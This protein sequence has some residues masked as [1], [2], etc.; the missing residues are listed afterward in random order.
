[1]YEKYHFVCRVGWHL[2]IKNVFD[3]WSNILPKSEN[4]CSIFSSSLRCH[5]NACRINEELDLAFK[6]GD[7]WLFLV[8]VFSS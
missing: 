3:K 1:M 6:R 8:I 2:K 7:I 4:M 5:G